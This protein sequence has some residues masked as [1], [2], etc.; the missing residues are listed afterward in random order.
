[1]GS[2]QTGASEKRDRRHRRKLRIP[3]V[4]STFLKSTL[5]RDDG[6]LQ[7][8]RISGITEAM[9]DGK[10]KK[11]GDKKE[12]SADQI[13]RILRLVL[14]RG[15]VQRDR[16]IQ[17]KQAK[18]RQVEYV[19]QQNRSR[20][21]ESACVPA[22]SIEVTGDQR[23]EAHRHGT[24]NATAPRGDEHAKVRREHQAKVIRG[25][26]ITQV[27]RKGPRY[28]GR[29]VLQRQIHHQTKRMWNGIG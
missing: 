18:S 15:E 21:D 4:R 9:D 7:R 22:K 26:R 10:Q 2:R 11:R 24:A 28:V 17:D 20:D 5:F 13:I 8:I 23:D 1:M 12:H 16:V 27:H 14:Q 6:C 3:C 19:A 29:G 25:Q